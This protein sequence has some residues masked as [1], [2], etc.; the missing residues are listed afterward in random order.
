YGELA[1]RSS[2][3]ARALRA[4]GVR[5]GDRVAVMLPNGFEFFECA[6]ALAKIDAALVPVNW[7]LGAE[8]LAWI[9][10]DSGASVLVTDAGIWASVHDFAGRAPE[11]SVVVVGGATTA[12]VTDYGTLPARAGDAGEG[13]AMDAGPGPALVF[14]T[15]GTTGRPKGVVH[16]R[17]SEQANRP[18][19]P[20]RSRQGLAQGGQ[21][22]LWRWT[23][24]EIHLL[25]GPAYHAGPC[26]W[27]LTALYAGATTVILPAWDARQWMTLVERHGVTR[28]FMVPSH[29]VRIL[30][31]PE[32]ER[33]RRDLSSLR[34]IVHAAAPCPTGVKRRMIDELPS[35]EIWELYGASEGGATRISPQEWLERPGSV[36]LP[37]PGVRVSI[38]DSEGR[39]LPPGGTGLVY[40]SPPG[41]ARFHYHNDVDK[42]AGA[43]RDDAFTVG[44]VGHL[45]DDGYLYITDRAS[46]MVIRGGVNVYPRE[47]EDALYAHPAVVDCAVFGVPDPVLGE[48]LKAVVELR[49]P[50]VGAEDLISHCRAR[51]ANFKCPE[52]LE[53]VDTLP[54]DPNGKVL[55]RLLRDAHWVGTRSA[56]AAE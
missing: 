40:I 25:S 19:A 52:I 29:F 41:G 22:A 3:V 24:D 21:V 54:R 50:G 44:D 30:E 18:S 14:Y 53:I 42:T 46:D 23:S 12:G 11:S 8:E 32:E 16:A 47:A 13:E 26:G 45:D 51:L 10:L 37:W 15:S 39:E 56:V 17:A 2:A 6:L 38:L 5:P 35:A 27:T 4:L 28:S 48:R 34:L 33:R 49:A 55:K 1:R 31:V 7:H 20:D 9:V 43:W 36:G